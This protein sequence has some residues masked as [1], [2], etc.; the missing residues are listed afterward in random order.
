MHIYVEVGRGSSSQKPGGR[1]Q[2]GFVRQVGNRGWVRIKFG[3]EEGAKM[4]GAEGGV[5]EKEGVNGGRQ[6][7]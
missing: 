1:S 2:G 7:V 4:R 5:T 6:A 3:P